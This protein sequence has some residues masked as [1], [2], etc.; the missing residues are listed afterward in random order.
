MKNIQTSTPIFT[1][2]PVSIENR[3]LIHRWL[4]QDYIQEWIHGEG[5]KNTLSGLD[6]FIEHFQQTQTIDRSLELTQH[7][8]GYADNIPF[9]YLLTSNVFES[10]DSIYAKHKK[11]GNHTITLDIF[12]GE[13]DYLGKGFATPLIKTFLKTHFKDVSEVFIDPEQTNQRAIHVYQKAGFQLIDEFIAPW[14]PV[15]HYLMRLN[16]E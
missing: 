2:K 13:P 5:L 6:D 9:V 16:Q 8:L 4:S 14:H 15:P 10:E 7:W 12:I 11:A 3:P 1:F